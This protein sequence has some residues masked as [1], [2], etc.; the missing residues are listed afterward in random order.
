MTV[1]EL[2]AQFEHFL[3]QLPEPLNPKGFRPQV[4]LFDIPN[5]RRKRIDATADKWP[6]DDREVRV[7]FVPDSKR[8]DNLAQ[9]LAAN[10]PSQAEVRPTVAS[11]NPL[12][13]LVHALNR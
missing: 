7:T 13:D 10:A 1:Q 5:S 4:A 3:S 12:T 8:I 2:A 6:P 11:A 9:P